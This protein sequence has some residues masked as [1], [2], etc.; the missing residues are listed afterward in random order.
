MTRARVHGFT[1]VELLITI[2]VGIVFLSA[3]AQMYTAVINDAANARNKANAGSIAY[4]EARAIFT[5]LAIGSCTPVASVSPLPIILTG[6]SAD[7]NIG[8][9]YASLPAPRAITATVTCPYNSTSA[10]TSSALAP[11]TVSQVTVT[12]TYGSSGATVRHVLYK[13]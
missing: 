2:V 10:Y 8:P 5:S 1:A 3:A 4:L 6:G 11:A 12:I 7:T 13:Y 9:V